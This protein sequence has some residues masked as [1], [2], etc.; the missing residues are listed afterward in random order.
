MA[1]LDRLPLRFL[2]AYYT[3]KSVLRAEI[4][5]RYMSSRV[6]IRLFML[7]VYDL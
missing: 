3:Y 7:L 4:F 6:S 2:L 1:P 5:G